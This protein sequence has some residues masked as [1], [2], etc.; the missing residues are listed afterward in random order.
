[1]TNSNGVSRR[2]RQILDIIY[3]IGEASVKDVLL[4][5]DDGSS[6]STVRTL[7]GIL[8]TKKKLSRQ[9]AGMKYIYKPTM[10]RKKASMLAL[11]RVVSTFFDESP[12]LAVNSLLEMK[13]GKITKEE[14]EQL[15]ALIRKNK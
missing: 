2:E 15:E 6:D 11:E 12:L 5:L 1:M 14:V 8:V 4:A 13:K 10:E 7:L 9:E 3:K